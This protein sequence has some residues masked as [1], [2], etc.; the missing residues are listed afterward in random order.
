MKFASAIAVVAV[1]AIGASAVLA[2]QD[3]IAAR[4]A[5]MKANGQSAGALAKMVK[6][7]APF[8]A[9]AAKKSFATFEDAAA[10]MPNLFP[11]NSKTGG[12]TAAA[13]KIWEDTADFSEGRR[14]P[15][16][17][18]FRDGEQLQRLP[19]GLSLE[20]ELSSRRGAIRADCPKGRSALSLSGIR[21]NE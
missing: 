14:Q 11:D 2:Q 12:E 1:T 18:L 21:A 4:K 9:D 8:D 15:Q 7:E 6:G 17:C 16:G 10:K 20:E 13:P 3:P 19:R 5:L